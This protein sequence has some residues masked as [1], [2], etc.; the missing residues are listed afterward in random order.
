MMPS[1]LDAEQAVLG[2]I[3]DQ[4]EVIDEIGGLRS[5]HF[6]DPVHGRLF[7]ALKKRQLNGLS[8]DAVTVAQAFQGDEGLVSLGG[9]AYLATLLNAAP[10]MSV[11]SQ[12]A[13]IVTD[14][15]ARR[16]IITACDA[17]KVK[18][19]TIGLSD[20]C[21]AP[22]IA[23]EIEAELQAIEDADAVGS[24]SFAGSMVRGFVSRL[25]GSHNGQTPPMLTFGMVDIDEALGPI[26]SEDVIILGG[27]TSMGKSAVAQQ[28]GCMIAEQGAGVMFFALEMS[29]DQM[30][31]RLVSSY[32]RHKYGNIAYKDVYSAYGGLKK[33]SNTEIEAIEDAQGVVEALPLIVDTRG[34][35]RPSQVM[36]AARKARRNFEVKGVKLGLIVIDHI[37][38]MQA[39]GMAR[40][41]YERASAIASSLK[42]MAKALQ[43]PILACVQIN[44]EAEKTDNKRPNRSMLRDS[45]RIEEIADSIL[46]CYRPSYYLE[47]DKPNLN[48]TEKLMEWKEKLDA[49][50]N[51]LS[52]IVD[53]A[54]MGKPGV[55]DLWFDPATTRIRSKI[56]N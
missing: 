43:V 56:T 4:P 36:A 1:N 35:L 24:G 9:V 15:A 23:S 19:E 11:V 22:R 54:R 3:L 48:D 29:D 40:S 42:V 12:Y 16:A 6:Y 34:G 53:K 30:S 25:V 49:T 13:A 10:S 51:D 26:G 31:A 44:R 46:L 33:L 37:G 28:L 2:A 18:A 55:I 47:R 14:M 50:R 52:L 45:G 32:Q 27:R 41:D 21:E 5:T 7:E 38:E 17:G 20:G 8:C 39:D